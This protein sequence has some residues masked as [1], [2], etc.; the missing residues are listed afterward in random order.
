M[1][2]KCPHDAFNYD[3]GNV[4]ICFAWATK[5]AGFNVNVVICRM[6][7]FNSSQGH[8]HTRHDGVQVLSV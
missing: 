4:D 8:F 2:L 5:I 3:A 1:C 7:S 6:H